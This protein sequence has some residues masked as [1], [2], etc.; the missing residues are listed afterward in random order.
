MRAALVVKGDIAKK[1]KLSKALALTKAH[2]MFTEVRVLESKRAG[3]SVALAQQ[4]VQ[5]EYD[6]LIAVGGDGT[7]NEVINGMLLANT[8]KLPHLAT[9][10]LGTA[11][12]FSRGIGLSGNINEI[13]SLIEK[14]SPKPTD[15]GKVDSVN[16]DGLP[17]TG[18]FLNIADAGI[19]GH[20]IDKVKSAKNR[21][22]PNLAFLKAIAESLLIYEKSAVQVTIDGNRVWEGNAL[23]VI[24]ANGNQF[25]SGLIVAPNAKLDNGQFEIVIFGNVSVY[26]Y[27][28]KVHRVRKGRLIEDSKVKYFQGQVIHVE[29]IHY[30]CPAEMD[31]EY[32]GFAPLT[33]SVLP[34]RIQFF[35]P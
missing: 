10:P 7:L 24:I 23:S 15:I 3:Q 29:P 8:S 20:V 6:L 22:G 32:I 19:G 28:T 5:E 35:R 27:L 26:E 13:L 30:S 21:L 31:G 34:N 25:G 16:N 1:R 33:I 2:P 11:C 18:Y 14:R 9:F 4:A 12:D 17:Q